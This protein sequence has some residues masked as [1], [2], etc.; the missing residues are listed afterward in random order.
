VL[1]FQSPAAPVSAFLCWQPGNSDRSAGLP[2]KSKVHKKQMNPFHFFT[3]CSS[4]STLI[5][6]SHL[7]LRL[8]GGFQLKHCIRISRLSHACYNPVHLIL[9]DLITLIIFGEAYK[10]R[11]SSLCD[12][13]HPPATCS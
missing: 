4:T 9:L 5:L 7:H 1:R 11:S 12:T 3:T 8:S 10:L 6:A 2:W 13:L